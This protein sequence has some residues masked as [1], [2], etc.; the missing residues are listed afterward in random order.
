MAQ[1]LNVRVF[2]IIR[3]LAL[4]CDLDTPTVNYVLKRFDAEGI[5]FLTKTLPKFSASVLQ[6]IERGFML[7]DKSDVK[8]FTGIKWKNRSPLFF[9]SLL[10]LI[11]DSESG[12]ALKSTAAALALRKLRQ[13]CE[14]F[15]K[16]SFKF[17]PEDLL[18]SESKYRQQEEALKTYTPD[19]T[20]VK[21]LRKVLFTLFPK[22]TT[23]RAEQ[24]FS[25]RTKDGPGAFAESNRI[26]DWVLYKKLPNWQTGSHPRWLSGFSGYFRAYPGSKERLAPAN[27]DRNSVVVFVPKD[28]RGP[29]VIS[30]EPLLILRAQMAFFK[31]ATDLLEKES[32][33]RIN[34][35]SQETNRELAKEGSLNGRWATMDLSDA[36]DSISMRLCRELF[37]GCPGIEYFLRNCRSTHTCLPVSKEVIPLMKLAGMGSGLTFPILALV[38]YLSVLSYLHLRTGRPIR[39]LATIVYVYGDDIIVPSEHFEDAAKGLAL[40]GLR[41]NVAKSY[42]RGNFRESCG[43]DYYNGIECAPVR[44]KVPGAQLGPVGSFNSVI[45][46]RTDAG[47]L[48]VERHARELVQSGLHLTAETLYQALEK[49]LGQLPP[50]SGDSSVLGRWSPDGYIPFDAPVRAWKPMPITRDFGSSLCPFKFLGAFLKRKEPTGFEVPAGQPFGEV[51]YPRKLKL[52][53]CQVTG[54]ALRGLTAQCKVTGSNRPFYKAPEG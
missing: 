15:Y 14:Y 49:A 17:T 25:A 48:Q 30:K 31:Y 22:L 3:A 51:T 2:A 46:I 13:F 24:I 4:D 50:V 41:L 16:C 47:I 7:R 26:P 54:T 9:S 36:S 33:H 34:F 40:S 20:W 11:F 32:L 27:C 10:S 6:Y 39:H 43:G 28:S 8:L 23:S 52:K 35:R 1:T 44:F 37:L 18:K 12:L 53:R 5:T 29:R 42:V 45:P 38:A 19:K 21:R